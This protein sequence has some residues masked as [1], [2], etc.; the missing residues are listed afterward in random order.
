MPGFFNFGKRVGL[1]IRPKNKIDTKSKIV[2]TNEDGSTIVEAITPFANYYSWNSDFRFSD[3]IELIK[4][5]RDMSLN[6]YC[7]RIINEIVNECISNDDETGTSV[8]ADLDKTTFTEDIKEKIIKEFNNILK[9][10]NFNNNGQNIFR[11]FYIDGR[12]YYQKIIDKEHPENGI[13]ELRKIDSLDI[14]K[15]KQVVRKLDKDTGAFIIDKEEEFY[16]YTPYYEYG[17]GGFT[18]QNLLFNPDA[19]AYA[20]SGLYLYKE[21][22]VN[23]SQNRNNITLGNRY[24]V[25][26]LYPMIKPL[27]QLNIIEEASIISQVSR[28]PQRRIHYVDISGMA[29]TKGEK[30]LKDYAAAIKNDLQYNS[31][32]G[33][34]NNASHTYSM[35][36]DLIIPRR[37][38]TNTAA[39]ETLPGNSGNEDVKVPEYFK[40]KVYMASHVP[41][42][43]M[44]ANAT[45]FLGRASEI[46]RDELNFSKF[47]NNLRENFSELFKDLLKTQLLLKH[48]VSYR[49]WQ[50][51]KNLIRF[52]YS[53]DTYISQLRNIEMIQEKISAL[54]DSENYVGKYF[55]KR[56]IQKNILDFDDEQ[57]EQL[58]DEMKREEKNEPVVQLPNLS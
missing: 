41:L 7:D 21:Q 26:F 57:I 5:F 47:C 49:D 54:R 4:K 20:S 8:S 13:I 15:I 51:N 34:Y 12:I 36:E 39:I 58:N 35:Q 17:N 45:S 29:P 19:I 10:L 44:D 56:Y 53:S 1:D 30:A 33:D 3:E 46:N 50:E 48:I 16:Q 32:T 55:S 37:N 6:V 40:M 9:L 22:P 38:G 28:A 31:D 52:I 18:A 25:S 11:E 27:N 14:K 23:S 2:S 24:I 42:S 43:R